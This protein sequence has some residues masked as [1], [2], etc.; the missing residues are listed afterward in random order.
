ME[1]LRALARSHYGELAKIGKAMASPVRLMLIDL[2]RQGPRSVELL[3][4]QAG[5]TVANA[6]QHLQQ[7][8]AANLVRSE[9]QAQRVVYR[10]NDEPVATLFSSVRELAEVVLPEMDRLAAAFDVLDPEERAEVLGRIKSKRVTLI[11]VRPPEE[12]EADHLPG[13]VS[14]PLRELPSRMTELPKQKEIVAY[15]R[16]PYCPLALQAVEMLKEAG[17]KAR[18]LDLGPPDIRPARRKK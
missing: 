5:V 8:A 17:F 12:F 10:L 6:S 2:L 9:K 7:L 16:G 1:D 14:M 11:D 15:C 18:H 4:E 3:A 13:A